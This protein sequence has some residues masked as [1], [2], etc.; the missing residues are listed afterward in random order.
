V[1]ED[2][3]EVN[4]A[5]GLDIALPPMTPV[6][7][8]FTTT[9][10]DDIAAAVAREFERPEIRACIRSGARI[11][12]GCGSR[13]VANYA[14][15]ARAV[16]AQIKALGGNPFVFPA[17]GSH[18]AA[19]AEG[20]RRVLE[21]AGITEDFVGAPIRASMDTIEAGRMADG[22]PV[23]ADAI[24][25]ATDGIVLINRIK[26]HTTFRGPI[27]SGIT[28]MLTIGMGKI[29]GA[30]QLHT[31]GMDRFPEVLPEA[32]R[33]VMGRLP[34]LF[35]VAAVENAHDDTALVECIPAARLLAREPELLAMAK[36]WMARLYF[37][38]IDVLVIDEM[39]KEISGAGFDP[40]VTGRN[41]RHVDWPGGPRI[42]KIA[43]LGLT[44]R[45]HGNA[46]GV[47]SADVITMRLFRAIDVGPTYANVITST[48]LDSAAIPMIMN[49]DREAVQLAVKSILRVKPADARVVHIRNTL[50]LQRIRVSAPLL[51]EVRSQPER[52]EILSEPAP[53]A[54]GTDGSLAKVDAE[55]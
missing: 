45:T 20:Q 46:T 53:W 24:A 43:V 41:R 10:V 34:F 25:A 11:A 8:K 19:T 40:N 35:G 15:I 39:G 52:F 36:E 2:R 37:D 22:T 17:M 33:V 23:Y 48:H 16:I 7:Q 31:H 38:G 44:E 9:R 5:G 47:G 1:I 32:A 18:G 42:K 6:R 55:G 51:A 30:A 3:I 49:T 28:K 26:P 14:H 50:E 27:E 13:G 29:K 4:I 54:F 21:G 12:V